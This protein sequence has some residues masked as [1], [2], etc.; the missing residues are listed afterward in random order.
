M[1]KVI[2]VRFIGAWNQALTDK[3]KMQPSDIKVGATYANKGAGT[4]QRKVIAI[5]E[6][7][8]PRKFFGIGNAPEEVGVLFEQQG[9]QNNLYLSSFAAWCGKPI[10][11][12]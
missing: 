9:K 12:P 6:E 4:T 10:T 11:D 5:G 8:R 1:E 7:H 3:E 2:S